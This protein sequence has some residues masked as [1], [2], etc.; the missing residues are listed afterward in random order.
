MVIM[1][2][3]D[4]QSATRAESLRV[5]RPRSNAELR[6]TCRCRP[7]AGVSKEEFRRGHDLRTTLNQLLH[8]KQAYMHAYAGREMPILTSARPFR[9]PCSS[10]IAAAL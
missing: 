4:A 10:N 3:L 9:G 8:R 6:F 5:R 2:A 7:I 1:L